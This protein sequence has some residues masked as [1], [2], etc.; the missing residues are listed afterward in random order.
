MYQRGAG[1]RQNTDRAAEMTRR[2][3][4]LKYLEACPKAKGA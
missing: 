1:V 2:A 3:C 4:Q